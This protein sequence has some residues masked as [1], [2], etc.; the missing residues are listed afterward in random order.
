VA[1]ISYNDFSYLKLYQ[2]LISR[3]EFWEEVIKQLTKDF[4]NNDP[5]RIEEGVSL[6]G[7]NVAELFV[8]KLQ[9]NLRNFTPNLSE[10]FYR[11]DLGEQQVESLKNLPDDIYYRCLAEMIVKRIILKVA[12]R[13][14]HSGKMD[15]S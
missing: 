4:G 13:L 6:E 12:S 2:N 10:I 11:V 15:I 3:K 14:M 9:N 5:I 1:D 8:E 7:E